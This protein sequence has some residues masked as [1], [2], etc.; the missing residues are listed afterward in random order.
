MAETKDISF[1]IPCYRS[2]QTIGNVVAEINTV[3]TEVVKKTYEI[4]LVNDG[5]PDK[6]GEICERYAAENN[7]IKV[8]HKEN[9][10]LSDARNYGL[11]RASNEYI[12]FIDSDDTYPEDA[13]E[14]LFNKINEYDCDIAFGRYLRH[15]PEKNLIRKSYTPY[16]DSLEK[17]YLDY[18]DDLVEG[19]NLKG[20]IGSLWKNVMSRFFYGKSIKKVN[21]EEIFIKDFKA[22]NDD[23]I[24]ILK[25]LPSFWSKIYRT[26]LI[27]ENGIKFPECISAEDLNFLL[28]SYIKS[29]K[30]ILFLN[31]K[32]VYN[33][34]MRLEDEDKSITKNINFRL[35]YDSLKAYRLSS[36]LSDKYGIRNKDL[37]L[38]PYLLNW[39]SLWRSRDN[40]KEENGIFL[41]EIEMMEKGNKNGLKYKLILKFIKFLLKIKS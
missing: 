6:C 14:T 39:I 38:N 11:E 16:I 8:Y 26:E 19:S 4:I 30:G 9:G 17:P 13:C 18:L 25:I 10:G 3:M 24:A 35:V 31:N 15:Y 36:E 23:E 1:V 7:I 27:K 20:F 33:Y 5:S 21:N 32:I 34:F 2:E 41:K 12:M 37:F 28:E 22:E 29:E 40:S